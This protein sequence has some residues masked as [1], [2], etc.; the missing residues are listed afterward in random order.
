M[1]VIQL[2]AKRAGQSTVL[3][4]V[5][6]DRYRWTGTPE[7]DRARLEA[8]IAENRGIVRQVALNL[9]IGRSTLKARIK[10]Y[11]IDISRLR[12]EVTVNDFIDMAGHVPPC[13]WRALHLVLA[14]SSIVITCCMAACYI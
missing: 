10:G 6:S 13:R 11:K 8:A 3:S 5:R 14:Y 9:G 1:E 4:L 2:C 7:D 12:N